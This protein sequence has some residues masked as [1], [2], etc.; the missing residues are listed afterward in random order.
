MADKPKQQNKQEPQ[1][2]VFLKAMITGFFGGILWS[3]VGAVAYYFNF[4]ELTAASFMFRSFLQTE[5]TGT[6][7]AEILAILL[8]GLLSLLIAILY[9]ILLK[10]KN[11]IW[12]GLFFGLSLWG[13]IFFVLRPIFPA[14][15]SFLELN[16]DTWVTSGCLFILYGVF[17]G[18][19]ISYEYREFNDAANSYSKEG[20]V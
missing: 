11:G 19:S 6:W 2:S 16:S 5:W 8:V 13:I 3:G 18:Y 14:I 10:N 17:I 20:G 15:P 1:Q 12:P 9:Y 7:L 4:T